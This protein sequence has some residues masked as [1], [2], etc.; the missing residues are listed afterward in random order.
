MQK[1]AQRFLEGFS[2][3]GEQEFNEACSGLAKAWVEYVSQG[4][5]YVLN[6]FDYSPPDAHWVK[7]FNIVAEKVVGTFRQLTEGTTVQA[8]LKV[9]PGD[10]KEGEHAKLIVVDDWITT[11]NTMR[12]NITRASNEAKAQGKDS[13]TKQLEGQVIIARPDQVGVMVEGPRATYKTRS[14]YEAGKES[15]LYESP[16]S[17]AHSSVDV[18]FENTLQDMHMYLREH[19][20]VSELPLLTFIDRQYNPEEPY[21][22]RQ[23]ELLRDMGYQQRMFMDLTNKYTRQRQE[24]Q[25]LIITPSAD[26][27][28]QQ[29][30]SEEMN[31]T[32]TEMRVVSIQRAKGETEYKDLKR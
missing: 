15:T 23:A 21:T 31:L 27:T 28:R 1:R 16:P 2:F 19:G 29:A 20:I 5:D 24:M 26:R 8:R 3:I 25:S 4:E 14:Y 32:E 13:L 30:L 17:G 11:G 10:W 6:L 22:P 7:S 18:G 9:K 12:N